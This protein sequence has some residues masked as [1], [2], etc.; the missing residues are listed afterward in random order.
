[1]MRCAGSK[2]VRLFQLERRRHW[3]SGTGG[4]K[5]KSR[6]WRRWTQIRRGGGDWGG[7]LG[8][9]SG[10]G[11]GHNFSAGTITATLS[12]NATTATTATNAA[13]LNNQPASFY[14]NAANQTAG[15]LA[16]ARL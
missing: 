4:E 14:Q 6:R 2:S 7:C 8:Q 1:M 13:N 3:A 9:R 11:R 12:G 15:T 5:R 10:S 16:D